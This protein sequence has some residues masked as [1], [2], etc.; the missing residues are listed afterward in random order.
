MRVYPH[1]NFHNW[2]RVNT[3]WNSHRNIRNPQGKLH[4]V[5]MRVV[6]HGNLPST[7]RRIIPYGKFHHPWMRVTQRNFHHN[8]MG[9]YLF[10]HSFNES[11]V[12]PVRWNRDFY[13][14]TSWWL[15][16][17]NIFVVRFGLREF[18]DILFLDDLGTFFFKFFLG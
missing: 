4:N 11:P 17:F 8:W 7:R 1:G 14:V 6:S 10:F 15:K 3:Q 5:W 2:M 16:W 9:V 12:A 18:R 13:E